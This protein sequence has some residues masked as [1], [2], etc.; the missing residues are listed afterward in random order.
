M[1]W[2]E[3]NEE[4]NFDT[5]DKAKL[6]E[7]KEGNYSEAVGEILFENNTIVLWE[8][9]LA[10]SERLPFR[11]HR[12]NYSCTCFTDGVAL[13]RNINGQIGLL[14]FEKGDHFYWEYHEEE[15]INDIE[16]IGEAIIKIAV[17]EEKRNN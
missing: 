2:T 14:R 7:A 4:G 1:I 15:L 5:W 10:P 17:V 11:R 8:I 9:I 3:I 12:N 6:K 13:I 16:N